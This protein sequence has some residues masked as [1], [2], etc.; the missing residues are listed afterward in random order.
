MNM[1]GLTPAFVDLL[2]Q[3]FGEFFA[4]TPPATR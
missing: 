4:K 1:W 3:G 2:E